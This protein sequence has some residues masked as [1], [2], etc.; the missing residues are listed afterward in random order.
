MRLFSVSLAFCAVVAFAEPEVLPNF[1][2]ADDGVEVNHKT[3]LTYTCVYDNERKRAAV[4]NPHAHRGDIRTAFMRNGAVEIDCAD[5]PEGTKVIVGVIDPVRHFFNQYDHLMRHFVHN[6]HFVPKYFPDGTREFIGG[7]TWGPGH[8]GHEPHHDVA[9]HLDTLKKFVKTVGKQ[10]EAPQTEPIRMFNAVPIP[11]PEV[12][13]E[14]SR[15]LVAGRPHKAVDPPSALVD[16]EVRRGVC[17]MMADDY[18][19]LKMEVPE[20]CKVFIS[21]P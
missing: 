9:H 10:I 21:C 7:C 6:H 3:H 5:V 18:C 11:V 19:F 12:F 13:S 16:P 14:E 1:Q 4:V 20:P 8:E 17:E 2:Q 15:R